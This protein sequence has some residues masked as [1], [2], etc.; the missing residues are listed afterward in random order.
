MYDK[1]RCNHL[2]EKIHIGPRYLYLAESTSL[3]FH[4]IIVLSAKGF[5]LCSSKITFSVKLCLNVGRYGK[6]ISR[7]QIGHPCATNSFRSRCQ[8]QILT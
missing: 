4:S 8:E 2:M 1:K 7:K 6:T 3:P 5:P